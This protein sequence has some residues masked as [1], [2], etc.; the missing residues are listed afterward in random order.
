MN[1]RSGPQIP[2]NL[3]YTEEHEWIS[4][5]SDV[6]TVGITDYAQSELGD[7]VFVELPEVGDHIEK[8]QVFGTVEAVKTVA[9]LYAPAPGEVVEVNQTLED[10]VEQINT[11]PYGAGWMIKIRTDNQ[12]EL[13]QLLSSQDYEDL[14]ADMQNPYQPLWGR[15]FRF[16]RLPL[17]TL[18]T[19][20][21]SLGRGVRV[22][23]FLAR[24]VGS[25][26]A[27]VQYEIR[28]VAILLIA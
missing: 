27:L 7:I 17:S 28:N 8:G 20:W 18:G 6:C 13:E 3:S 10:M 11:D 5:D 21:K 25:R 2:D 14:V 9:E 23:A 15:V 12:E 4:Q 24:L 19:K 22:R 16:L 26:H 1:D